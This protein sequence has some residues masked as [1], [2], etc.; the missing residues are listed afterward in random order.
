MN[1]VLLFGKPMSWALNRR[2]YDTKR[3]GRCVRTHT[4]QTHT[5]IYT[6]QQWGYYWNMA[7]LRGLTSA[8]LTYLS[9]DSSSH[10]VVP[11]MQDQCIFQIER[12]VC[13]CV[14]TQILNQIVHFVQ[15]HRDSYQT[16]NRHQQCQEKIEELDCLLFLLWCD[17]QQINHLFFLKTTTN[18]IFN[19][20]SVLKQA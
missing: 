19:A 9:P 12:C 5:Y 13:V 8:L 10:L 14:C 15:M 7:V 3:F 16:T 11:S 6:R 1:S 4:T 18:E 17:G 2:N 20:Q